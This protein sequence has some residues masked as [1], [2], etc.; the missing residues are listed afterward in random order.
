MPRIG[1]IVRFRPASIVV[2]AVLMPGGTIR[3]A[4]VLLLLLCMRTD[5]VSGGRNRRI[6]DIQRDIRPD[7]GGDIFSEFFLEIV[8]PTGALLLF[9][10]LGLLVMFL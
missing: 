10:V 8:F 1:R 9:L 5:M 2:S 6:R 7:Q 3:R 4:D